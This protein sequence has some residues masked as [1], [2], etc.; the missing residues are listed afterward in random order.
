MRT[1]LLS[2]TALMDTK[3]LGGAGFPT[4]GLSALQE[5]QRFC[6]PLSRRFDSAQA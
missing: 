2:T 1:S 5:K 3:A 6:D 4:S